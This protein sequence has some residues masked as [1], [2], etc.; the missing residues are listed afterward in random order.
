M[1]INVSEFCRDPGKWNQLATD[2]LR[3]LLASGRR[4][5]IWSAGCS[6]GAEPYTLAM[7]TRELDPAGRHDILATD[8]DR[9]IL[10]RAQRGDGYLPADVR[11]LSPQR[12]ARFFVKN[13]D[14]YAVVPELRKL[15]RFQQHNLISDAFERDFDL[16]LCRN[17]VIY[18][19]EDVKDG[20][21]ERFY[22][23]LRAGGVLFVGGTEVIHKA[24][25]L[26]FES[27]APSF[28]RRVA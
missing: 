4:L 6:I 8:L 2:I 23:S 3:P 19:T 28:Y 21:Y 27:A 12:L 18:F 1:T 13:G 17:V 25:A 24:R 11:N 5:R 20:L 7:L 9:T 16:I 26:G 22:S 15:V 10:A 14:R